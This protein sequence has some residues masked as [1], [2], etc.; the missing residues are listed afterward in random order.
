M[1]MHLVR[2][3]AKSV[4]WVDEETLMPIGK[5]D[6]TGHDVGPRTSKSSSLS[7][8]SGSMILRVYC[9]AERF[10]K[11]GPFHFKSKAHAEEEEVP[12][13]E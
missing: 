13:D 1:T 8:E 9:A 4:P 5:Q 11:P 2:Q 10:G 7:E 12:E 3:S 6:S